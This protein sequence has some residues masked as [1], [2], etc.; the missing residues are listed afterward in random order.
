M[1]KKEKLKNKE[2]DIEK[3]K[4]KKVL[5]VLNVVKSVVF[6]SVMTVLAIAVISF[7]I[8]RARGGTPS[9]FGY[10][11]HKVETGSMEPT[12]MVEDVILSKK[13]D[14]STALKVGDIV[15]FQGGSKY[16]YHYITHRICKAPY[17][18]DNGEYYLQ[19]KG[20][21]NEVPDAEIPL[22]SVESVYMSK[23]DILKSFYK[24]FLSPWGLIVFVG[25]LLIIFF[26]EVMNIVRILTDNYPEEKEESIAEI[27]QRIQREDEEK[28]IA[29]KKKKRR[30]KELKQKLRKNK[31]GE[32]T[33]TKKK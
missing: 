20:D 16:D 31:K 24:F 8:I 30:E 32:Q 25:M 6:W 23:V 15:T 33:K 29:E 5:H 28:A 2:P 13:I 27:M 19:T 10:T 11:L 4:L 7:L 1:K 17:K 3:S 12:L 14:A 18:R 9:V 26:D 21:A 22:S